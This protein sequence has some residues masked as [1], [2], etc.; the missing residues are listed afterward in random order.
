M[1]PIKKLFAVA[2]GFDENDGTYFANVHSLTDGKVLKCQ[3][4][5]AGKI[6]KEAD[7]AIRAKLKEIKNF[8]LP[9]PTAEPS[10][11]LRP[12]GTSASETPKLTVVRG[13]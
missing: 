1:G 3:S 6:L 5:S 8:P 2:I 11:I 4:I 12:N 10:P 9:E 7:K 13:T